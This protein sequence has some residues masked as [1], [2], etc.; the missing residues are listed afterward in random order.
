MFRKLQIH[1]GLNKSKTREQFN[2]LSLEFGRVYTIVGKTGSGKTQLIEDIESLTNGTG[3]TKRTIL[4]D[5]KVP[6]DSIRYAPHNKLVSHLSQNMHFIL[7][8]QV[9]EFIELHAKCR[10]INSFQD[11]VNH[12]LTCANK[13]CGERILPNEK[14]TNLSGG[15]S[16]ALMIADI[17]IN[18][19][20]PIV[21]IDEIENAGINK[22][23]AVNM[24]LNKNKI[25]IIVTHDPLLALTG[26]KRIVMSNGG[27]KAIIK[28][29][30]TE[31]KILNEL[32]VYDQA[33]SNLRSSLR[34]GKQLKGGLQYELQSLL[35]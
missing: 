25:I 35:E 14:L 22:L 10:E 3:L 12:I 28:R 8:M 2:T 23:Q 15:Q 5:N 33:V 29:S 34:L 19:D 1:A 7:D 31:Q 18:G 13:L 26:D 9:N 21:L 27:V 6:C 24:L 11:Q 20:T 16:R 17:A 4:L 30:N 32:V